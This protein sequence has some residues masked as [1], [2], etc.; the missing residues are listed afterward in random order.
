M[1]C[2]LLPDFE[3]VREGRILHFVSGDRRFALNDRIIREIINSIIAEPSDRFAYLLQRT[4][5]YLVLDLITR[6][7]H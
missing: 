3:V 5:S 6:E 4:E 7:F 2:C 1:T